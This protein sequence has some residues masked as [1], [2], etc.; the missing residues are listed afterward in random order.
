MQLRT[1]I[2]VL[3]ITLGVFRL[4]MTTEATDFVDLV[5]GRSLE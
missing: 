1:R 2:F 4:E 5:L 3:S